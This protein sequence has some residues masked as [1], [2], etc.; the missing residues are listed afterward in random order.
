MLGWFLPGLDARLVPIPSPDA[1]LF[2]PGLDAR[3]VPT[4]LDVS[5]VWFLPGL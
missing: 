4:S 2:L 1:R 3:L 5:P